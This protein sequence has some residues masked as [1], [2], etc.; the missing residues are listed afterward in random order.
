MNVGNAAQKAGNSLG[1]SS[2][3]FGA[4]PLGGSKYAHIGVVE[5][6]CGTDGLSQYSDWNGSSER[7]SRTR[8]V[9]W[10]A[11]GVANSGIWFVRSAGCTASMTRALN[12]RTGNWYGSG[13][14]IALA[15][16]E[17]AGRH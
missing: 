7:V 2:C 3:V 1:H 15:L 9:R 13:R 12:A 6:R 17:V 16:D 14:A 5:V 11:G 10:T 8:A 4:D